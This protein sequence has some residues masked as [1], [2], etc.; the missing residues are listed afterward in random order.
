MAFLVTRGERNGKGD[1][2]PAVWI[3]GKQRQDEKKK[4]KNVS[5]DNAAISLPP[6]DLCSPPS[7]SPRRLFPFFPFSRQ[8]A[9]FPKASFVETYQFSQFSWKKRRIEGSRRNVV[10]RRTRNNRE[11]DRRCGGEERNTDGGSVKGGPIDIFFDKTG[12]DE[13]FS[14]VVATVSRLRI[15]VIIIIIIIIII[16]RDSPRTEQAGKV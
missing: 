10:G 14:G 12:N 8:L 7:N 5:F 13:L 11:K 1:A 2:L 15:I 16:I 4:E 6:F 3:P 9:S